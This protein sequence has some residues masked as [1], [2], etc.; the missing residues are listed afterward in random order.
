MFYV[1][2][3]LNA[4]TVGDLQAAMAA[5]QYTQAV[6]LAD[7]ALRQNP[8]DARLWFARG[9]ALSELGRTGSSLAS[10]DHALA[11]QPGA[12]PVLEA[13]AQVAY[14]V[15]DARAGT[16]LDRILTIDTHNATAHAMHGVLDYERWDCGGAITHFEEAGPVLTGNLPAEMQYGDCLDRS[17]QTPAALALFEQL[18]AAQ[19]GDGTPAYNVAALQLKA[20]QPA[21]AVATLEAM[22]AAGQLLDGATLN[23]LGA[24]YAEA[25]RL[26]D[27]I[28]A[29]RAAAQQLPTDTRNYLDLA[30][31]S[32]DHQSFDTAIQV[33]DAGIRLNPDSAA[34]YAMR[35]AVHA[36]VD[37]DAAAADFDTAAKLQPSALYGTVGMGLLLRDQSKLPQAESLLRTRLRSAPNDPVLH[38]LLADV[39]VRQGAEPG[40]PRFREAETLLRRAI[41]LQPGL[42]IAYGTLGQ[43]ELRAGNLPPAIAELEAGVR[44]DPADR[45]SLTQLISAY[46]HA[47][48]REDA[49]RVAGQ[50]SKLVDEE[51]A[52]ADK[53]NRALLVIAPA[54]PLQ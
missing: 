1:A 26:P 50:L 52:G 49:A 20:G 3:P 23:L 4:Q 7:R 33:L 11:T 14:T 25:D 15:H 30:A 34:L 32:I 39:L 45:L 31:L 42:A 22:R 36:Q 53:R 5:H 35:G 37:T 8:G 28:S 6:T 17:G 46:R 27:A 9:V 13:A 19:P 40:Q 21:Q 51:R 12:L 54:A 47:G 38:Y 2:L 41:A 48:R 10:F 16:Y 44:M 29:Y 43:L 24:A 18:R